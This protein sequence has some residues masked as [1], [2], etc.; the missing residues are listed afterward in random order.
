MPTRAPNTAATRRQARSRALDRSP[1]GRRA[2][3]ACRAL[4]ELRGAVAEFLKHYPTAADARAAAEKALTAAGLDVPHPQRPGD[5][6]GAGADHFAVL[7]GE[8]AG[9]RHLLDVLAERLADV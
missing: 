8:L 6:Y 7:P 9:W 4:G 5:E 2:A 3:A 1:I